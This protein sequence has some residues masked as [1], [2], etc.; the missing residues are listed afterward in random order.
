MFDRRHFAE[1]LVRM[2]HIEVHGYAIV[3]EDDRIADAD[4]VT[5]A[6]LRNDADWSYFQ[7]ELD[8]AA[9]T[10]LGRAGHELNPNRR[11]RLRIVL[12][13]SVRDLE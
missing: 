3:S 12:S 10:V 6:S 4:G 7:S 13:T 1:S 11:N 2:G 8:R 9:V 5:P